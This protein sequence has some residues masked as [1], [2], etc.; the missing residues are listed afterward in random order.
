MGLRE[1]RKKDTRESI[2]LSARQRFFSC[3]YK[4]TSMGEIAESSDVAVGTLYNYFKSKGEIMLAIANE[5]SSDILTP[6]GNSDMDTL[7]VEDLVWQFTEKLI[8]FFS[9]YPRELI[10]ELI[11]VFWEAGQEKLSDGL[12]SIDIRIMNQITEMITTL[13]RNGRIKKETEPQIVALALY[14]MA[15]TAVMWYSV[16]PQMTLAKTRET[17][18]AMIGHFCRGILPEEKE[19]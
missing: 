13:R 18:A 12:A 16:D 4:E 6:P 15:T 10:K 14:G 7:S 11:G 5:D 3:G 8:D 19:I 17:I 2:I 9:S 1:R